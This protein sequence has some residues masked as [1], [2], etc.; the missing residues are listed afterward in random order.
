MGTMDNIKNGTALMGKKPEEAATLNTQ[1][2]DDIKKMSLD[3][4]NA[5]TGDAT[6]GASTYLTNDVGPYDSSNPTTTKVLYDQAIVL[7][8][9]INGYKGLATAS[10]SFGE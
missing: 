7:D 9:I 3:F 2:K 8:G 5:T 4:T 10:A 6:Y 1:I